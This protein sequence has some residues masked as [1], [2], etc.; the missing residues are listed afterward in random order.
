MRATVARIDRTTGF[1]DEQRG[2]YSWRGPDDRSGRVVLAFANAA[3]ATDIDAGLPAIVIFDR[4]SDNGVLD[5]VF[6]RVGGWFSASAQ[7]GERSE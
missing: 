1:I 4:R 5:G 3:V 6:A 7:A 2:R